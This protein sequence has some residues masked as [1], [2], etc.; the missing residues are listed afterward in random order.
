MIVICKF[1]LIVDYAIESGFAN[2]IVM[3]IRGKHSYK[4][5]PRMLLTM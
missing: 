3:R 5:I 1:A 4:Y 2:N